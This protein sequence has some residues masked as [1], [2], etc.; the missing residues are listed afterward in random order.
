MTDRHTAY[1]ITLEG[2]VREDDA[3]DGILIA[4]RQI[5]GVIAVNPVIS[6]PVS[7]QAAITRRDIVWTR[8]LA[9]LAGHMTDPDR[10][11]DGD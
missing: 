7:E 3:R 2:P 10:R 4:L 11:K 8:A 5:R 9:D 6:S 1:L